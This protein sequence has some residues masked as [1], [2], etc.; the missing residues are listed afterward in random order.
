MKKLAEEWSKYAYKDLL[1]IEKILEDKN[2]TNI[3]AFHAQ[4]CI[5]KSFK[6][7]ILLETNEIPKIHNLLKLY[8]TVRNYRKIS[9]EMKTLELI[10][11]TYTDTRYPSELGLLPDGIPS[12]EMAKKFYETAKTIYDQIKIEGTEDIQKKI[13]NA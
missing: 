11:E 5:E 13:T 6:A 1:T 2:L 7:L 9:F 8:G 12:V 4:Q 3:T 10:N